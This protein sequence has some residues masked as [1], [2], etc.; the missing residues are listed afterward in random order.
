MISTKAG[1]AIEHMKINENKV[2][3]RYDGNGDRFEIA[4][5]QSGDYAM[6]ITSNNVD[7]DYKDELR[8]FTLIDIEDLTNMAQAIEKSKSQIVVGSG[9]EF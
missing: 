4:K 3:Y 6:I 7:T 5:Y 8:S 1:K 2:I 9:M